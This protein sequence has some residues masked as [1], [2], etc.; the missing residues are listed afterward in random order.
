MSPPKVSYLDVKTQVLSRI[1]DGT[2]APGATIPGEVE[3]ATEFGCARTTVN[4]ALQELADEGIVDRRRKA[5]TRVKTSP[6][7]QARFTIPLIRTEIEATGAAYRYAL[8]DRQIA[9]CPPGLA[10]QLGIETNSPMVHL[11]CMHY[12]DAL[13]FQYEDRW[14]NLE[15]VPEAK[16][17]PFD[18]INPNEWLVSRVPFSDVELSFSATNASASVADFLSAPDGSALFT[19]ERTTWLQARPVT[20]ARMLFHPGYRMTTLV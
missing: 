20:F 7:R 5:G 19:A 4:R 12:A 6:T 15:T 9:P 3:L 10:A 16:A 14:I 2:W 17:E 1:H 18:V 8:V 13:A 11:S